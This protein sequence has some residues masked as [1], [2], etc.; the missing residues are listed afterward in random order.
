[1]REEPS[2]TFEQILA[3]AET[4]LAPFAV[5]ATRHE[6][7][8]VDVVVKR[9]HLREA[10]KA[11][12]DARWGYLITITGLDLPWPRPKPGASA[13]A[14]PATPKPANEATSGK[15]GDVSAAE[16]GLPVED[17]LE[18]LYHFTEGPV[19]ATLRVTVPYADP[20]IPSICPIVP[21]ATLYEREL[22]EMFGFV[23]EETPVSDRLVLPDDWPDG[24]YPLRKSFTGLKN[25]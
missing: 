18:A 6:D 25:A 24:V 13:S 19:V 4:L 7:H 21:T 9:E 17:K 11:L 8:R 3:R 2:M 16:P 1:M 12:V 22:Q 5:G 15:A 10:V 20:R 23:I 14:A